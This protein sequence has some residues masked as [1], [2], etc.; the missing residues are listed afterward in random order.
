[1]HFVDL[2]GPYTAS[3]TKQTWLR[4]GGMGKAAGIRETKTV[5]AV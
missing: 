5:K 2:C 4:I 3:V 1:M